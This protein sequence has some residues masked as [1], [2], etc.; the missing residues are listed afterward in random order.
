[1]T[2]QFIKKEVNTWK[3]RVKSFPAKPILWSLFGQTQ[4]TPIYN[5][6]IIKTNLQ[7]LGYQSAYREHRKISVDGGCVQVEAVQVDWMDF[8]AWA[9]AAV[10]TLLPYWPRL[11]NTNRLRGCGGIASYLQRRIYLYTLRSRPTAAA[12]QLPSV[13]C[14]RNR[15]R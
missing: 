11:Q 14:I 9:V 3:C 5:I 12:V 2:K 13:S 8:A 6:R 1:M 7:N 4:A 10:L 15:H